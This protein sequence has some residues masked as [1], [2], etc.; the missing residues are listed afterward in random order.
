MA[1]TVFACCNLLNKSWTDNVT[2]SV[3]E[4]I[5]TC[6]NVFC[7]FLNFDTQST[8]VMWISNRFI[9]NEIYIYKYFD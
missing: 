2:Q 6:K 3:M 7:C 1:D 4:F 8:I 5:Y 9:D